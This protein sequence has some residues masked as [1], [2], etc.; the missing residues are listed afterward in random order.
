MKADLDKRLKTLEADTKPRV[1]STLANYVL[2]VSEYEH[3]GKITEAEI[4]P[5]L[6]AL[7]DA[8]SKQMRMT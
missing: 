6:Q 3:S 8:T 2:W 5:E 7:I 4:C 1:I